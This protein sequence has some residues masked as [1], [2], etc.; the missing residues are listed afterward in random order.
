MFAPESET[1]KGFVRIVFVLACDRLSAF[2]VSCAAMA[3]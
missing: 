2:D 1:P 3:E